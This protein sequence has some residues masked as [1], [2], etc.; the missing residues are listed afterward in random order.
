MAGS[1]P[2]TEAPICDAWVGL[3]PPESADCELPFG[4][5]GPH[6]GT[7]HGSVRNSEGGYNHAFVDV[8]WTALINGSP[9]DA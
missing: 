4:H 5:E 1:W 7:L 3:E 9:P 2:K 6:Q 8:K